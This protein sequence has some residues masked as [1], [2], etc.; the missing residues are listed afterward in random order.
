[1]KNPILPF[2][3][4]LLACMGCSKN[5]HLSVQTQ[6][7]TRETLASYYVETPDPMLINPPVGQKLLISWSLP[8]SYLDYA[9]LH[10]NIDIRFHNRGEVTLNVPI[11]KKCGSYMYVVANEKF[12]ETN[13]IL[14]YKVGLIGGN[15]LL[16]EWR[17]QLWHELI[18]I[19]EDI[20]DA[21]DVKD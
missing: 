18:K 4:L 8:R 17:Q 5:R 20:K 19:G 21:R 1:M 14:T 6:Y 2:L 11:E 9:D 3:I 10:L 15:C 16:E 12:F 13:G 7:F